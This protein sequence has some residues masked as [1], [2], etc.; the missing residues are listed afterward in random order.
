MDIPA[1]EAGQTTISI[2][3]NTGIQVIRNQLTDCNYIDHGNT[4]QQ[5]GG[6]SHENKP[7]EDPYSVPSCLL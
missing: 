2:S 4:N 1:S 3:G 7:E 6:A 5:G